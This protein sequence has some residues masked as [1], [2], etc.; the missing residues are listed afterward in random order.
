MKKNDNGADLRRLRGNDLA[1]HLVRL[2]GHQK[3]VKVV[4]FEPIW[5]AMLLLP[6]P[7]VTMMPLFQAIFWGGLLGLL[8]ESALWTM[9]AIKK[10]D[11]FAYPGMRTWWLQ[12][13]RRTILI[14]GRPGISSSRPDE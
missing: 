8:F 5:F 1:Q 10:G 13:Q 12:F 6:L 9:Y 3:P 11:I 2:N 7:F 14:N 4:V